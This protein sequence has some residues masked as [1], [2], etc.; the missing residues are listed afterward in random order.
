MSAESPGNTPTGGSGGRSGRGRG[1]RGSGRG[2]SSGGRGRSQHQQRQSTNTTFTGKT[3]DLSGHIYDLTDIRRS[4]TQYVETTKEIVEYIGREYKEGRIVKQAI[5]NMAAAVVHEPALPVEPPPPADAA[6]PTD[7]EIEARRAYRRA[8]ARYGILM[9]QSL[10]TEHDVGE[11]MFKAYNLILGQCTP[12]LVNA[13][14]SRTA[15]EQVQQNANP[16]ELLRMIRAETRQDQEQKHPAVGV[17]N[18]LRALFGFRQ[19]DSS[20]E[21]YIKDFRNTVEAIE[22]KG[23]DLTF[24]TMTDW[25]LS[26]LNPPVRHENATVD[27]IATAEAE[28]KEQLLAVI[29]MTGS[30]QKKY[31]RLVEDTANDYLKGADRYPRTMTQTAN[32][33]NNWRQ[34]PRNYAQVLGAVNDGVAFAQGGEERGGGGGQGT[35]TCYRCGRPNHIAPYCQETT[36]LNGTA[37]LTTTTEN[38]DSGEQAGA[39]D[40]DEGGVQFCTIGSYSF[41]QSSGNSW[42]SPTTLLIDSCSDCDVISNPKLLKNI[43][44]VDRTLHIR[45]KAGVTRTNKMG[46]LEGYDKEVWYDEGGVANILA[47]CNVE[48]CFQVSY[49][50]GKFT[51][52]KPDGKTRVFTRIGKGIYGCDLKSAHTEEGDEDEGDDLDENGMVLALNSVETNASKYTVRQYRQALLARRVHNTVGFPSIRKFLK[53]IA[54]NQIQ[55]CPVTRDDVLIAEDIFGPN[56]GALKGKTVRRNA[57]HVVVEYTG[58]PKQLIKSFRDVTL[59][60]DIMFV[61]KMP[62]FVTVSRNIKFRTVEFMEGRRVEHAAKAFRSAARLYPKRGFKVKTVLSDNEF[63]AIRDDITKTGADLHCAGVGKHTPEIERQIR[64]IKDRCRCVYGIVPY[65]RMPRMMVKE[66]VYWSVMWLN[67]FPEEDGVSETMSPREIMT[68]RKTTYDNCKLEFG[69]YVQT[70]EE[71]DN[72]MSVRT[73]GAI[74]LRPSGNMQGGYYFMNLSTGARIHRRQW[75]ELPITRDVVDRVHYL[76]DRSH[77]PED[78]AFAWRDGSEITGTIQDYGNDDGYGDEDYVDS[79]EEDVTELEYDDSEDDLEAT[80]DGE[81]APTTEEEEEGVGHHSLESDVSSEDES[82]VTYGPAETEDDGSTP[83]ES[84]DDDYEEGTDEVD[85]SFHDDDYEG[86]DY[87]DGEDGVDDVDVSGETAGVAESAGVAETTGVAATAGVDGDAAGPDPEVD[88]SL[89]ARMDARYGSRGNRYNLRPRRERSYDHRTMHMAVTVDEDVG[90]NEKLSQQGYTL[91]TMGDSVTVGEKM[92]LSTEQ[93]SLRQGLKEFG[94]DAEDAVVAEFKQL[95]DRNV[96]S[97]RMSH[98]LS[99][100]EKRRAL[101]YLMFLKRKRCGRV[102]ARGCA[103][104]RPQR[105]YKS[106]ED[107]SSPTVRLES[108]LLSSMIDAHERRTVVT[109]DIP[110][111]FMQTDIDEI[112]HVRL[113]GKMA[114]LLTKVDPNKY[115][116]YLTE[117][118]GKQV[119]YVVLNKALYG[120]LQGALLFWKGK[121]R[122]HDLLAVPYNM[123]MSSRLVRL[124]T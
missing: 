124:R 70:H 53:I 99:R 77:A 44:S 111:A 39:D 113:E 47:L 32:L 71:H 42:L 64:T 98:M 81:G 108:I 100:E 55:N 26:K 88:D 92:S 10:Q 35:V 123:M 46:T 34:D 25:R 90:E 62:F 5:T 13:L 83:G 16:V 73:I 4:S 119:L 63:E 84:P 96:A 106:K 15:F 38:G 57:P 118:K 17:T 22:D 54:G 1:G 51:V 58:V 103:D 110:G 48:D 97:P 12:R 104:G 37:L 121:R 107:T 91:M 101:Q 102:K 87:D 86:T 9:K 24:R 116:P 2:R 68:G 120:T 114:E 20:N 82:G 76:A 112:V 11:S 40:E 18:A 50:P 23:I 66:L 28:G 78:L 85:D 65:N 95:H 52:T 94:K 21:K 27:Q 117:E 80:S 56:L 45:S 29:M 49:V 93:M 115:V 33:L 6:H 75:T 61:N 3:D 89:A 31:G 19:N 69:T 41:H 30:N 36:H 43:R 14:E 7:E 67:S 122:C 105:L 74:A 79:G 59:A 72:S 60:I 109:C 8:E